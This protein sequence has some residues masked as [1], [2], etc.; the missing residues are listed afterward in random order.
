M[1][2][3]G[4]VIG[5]IEGNFYVLWYLNFGV[6]KLAINGSKNSKASWFAS[7]NDLYECW[8][9]HESMV[10][11]IL[12]QVH[13][14]SE[15]TSMNVDVPMNKDLEHDFDKEKMMVNYVVIMGNN[16]YHHL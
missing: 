11:K 15:I 16:Y 10:A 7:W 14:P 13:L 12:R 4:M 3:N 5:P 2:L 6:P 9:P 1:D 8:S